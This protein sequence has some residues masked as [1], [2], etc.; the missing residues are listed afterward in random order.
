MKELTQNL[1]VSRT[2]KKIDEW[3]GKS[4]SRTGF[5]VNHYET[6]V[7]LRWTRDTKASAMCRQKQ[8]P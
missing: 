4:W 7:K 8:N 6:K 3:V 1:M 5:S 2:E